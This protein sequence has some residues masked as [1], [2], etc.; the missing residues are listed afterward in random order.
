MEKNEKEN[1]RMLDDAIK[2]SVNIGKEPFDLQELKK[3]WSFRYEKQLSEEQLNRAM[4]DIERDYYFWGKHFMTI[5]QYGKHLM[6]ME[7]YS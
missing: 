4:K 1:K 3:H 6:E 7:L 2:E 5:Q